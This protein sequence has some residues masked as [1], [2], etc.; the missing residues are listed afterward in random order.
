MDTR[1][2]EPENVPPLLIAASIGIL[3]IVQSL[4]KAGHD[5]NERCTLGTALQ[6]AATQGHDAVLR[7]LLKHGADP[8][9]SGRDNYPLLQAAARFGTVESVKTLV[10]SGADMHN[11]C[12][13]FGS[14]LIAA[15]LSSQC[16]SSGEKSAEFLLDK[17]VNIDIM[18]KEHGNALQAACAQSKANIALIGDLVSRGIEADKR[19]GGKYGAALQAACAHNRN[20]PVIRFLLS[21]A[22]PCVEVEDSKYCTALQ[23]ICAE[24]GDNDKVVTMLLNLGT[25]KTVR[26]GKY[27]T[28]LHAAC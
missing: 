1:E 11:E 26:G 17:G 5:A 18:S 23:A 16:G 4:L 12:D 8:N 21:K 14:S 3:G 27:G 13:I 15:C 7:C 24:S 19:G 2:E 10:A 28:I 25:R 20:E 6:T 22:D 9:L